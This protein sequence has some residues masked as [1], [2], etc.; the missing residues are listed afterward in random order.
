MIVNGDFEA[1]DGTNG[2]N[3]TSWTKDGGAYGRYT[4]THAGT[5]SYVPGNSTSN[6]AGV[7]QTIGSVLTAGQY[8]LEFWSIPW[9]NGS[10]NDVRVGVNAGTGN[11]DSVSNWTS[12]A[13]NEVNVPTYTGGRTTGAWEFQS[14]TFTAVGGE[15]T[16]YFGSADLIADN[17]ADIDDVSLT[18]VPEPSTTALLG[19]GALA[20]ILRRRK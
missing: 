11:L 3:A 13:L 15:D 18:A 10:G 17:G 16:V 12:L 20:L 2:G 7:Y 1:G 8:T 19:L 4:L 5:Y 6:T 14:Y 9:V